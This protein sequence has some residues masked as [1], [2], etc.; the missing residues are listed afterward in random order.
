MSN[1]VITSLNLIPTVLASQ[2]VNKK[3]NNLIKTSVLGKQLKFL[4]LKSVIFKGR[5]CT[6]CAHTSS[7][8]M[9]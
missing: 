5:T 2:N 3:K 9:K 6:M 1:L 4:S 7:T 8:K